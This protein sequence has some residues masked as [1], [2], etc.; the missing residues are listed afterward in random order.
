[1]AVDDVLLGEI[2]EEQS[3]EQVARPQEGRIVAQGVSEKFGMGSPGFY[4]R[5]GR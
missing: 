2:I 5:T 4:S 1:M 3:P